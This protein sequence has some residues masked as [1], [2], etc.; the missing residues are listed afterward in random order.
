MSPQHQRSELEELDD[1]PN[2]RLMKRTK[3]LHERTKLLHILSTEERS[4]LACPAK[5]LGLSRTERHDQPLPHLQAFGN[6]V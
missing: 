6:A 1:T 2:K 3:V 4:L 5:A